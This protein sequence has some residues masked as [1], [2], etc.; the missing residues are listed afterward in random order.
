MDRSYKAGGLIRRLS[1]FIVLAV[2]PCAL[3]ND[4][5]PD[6]SNPDMFWYEDGLRFASPGGAF[7]AHFQIRGQT[8][9]SDVDVD[10]DSGVSVSRDEQDFELNRGRFKLG[11]HAGA[12]W[13]KYYTEYDFTNHYLIDIW[14]EPRPFEWLGFRIGQY[15]VPYNRERFNS[16]G[17]QQFAERSVVTPPFTLDR[18]QGITALGRLFSGSAI[19]SSY[20]AGVYKGAGR[21]GRSDDDDTPMLMGRWQWNYNRRV[22]PFSASDITRTQKPTGALSIAGASNRSPFTRYSTAGGGQLT[23][24]EDTEDGDFDL[25]QGMAEYAFMYQGF[26]V[27]TEY[28]LKRVRDREIHENYR[29]RGFYI[30]SGYFFGELFEW[31]PHPLELAVRWSRV[32]SDETAVQPRKGEGAMG[33]NWFFNGHRNKL[34]FDVT[35]FYEE[36]PTEKGWFWGYRLQWDVSI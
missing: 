34:T 5:N 29:L 26:S 22:L 11:G 3:A 6:R 18:Q 36:S 30:D 23:G 12:E 28:H 2:S 32:E 21:A 14:I 35:R 9:Y 19:D 16:S 31:V 24:F 4:E 8:R 17:K 10:E 13:M 1:A 7:S 20:W 25:R 33:V 27:Q 15:K